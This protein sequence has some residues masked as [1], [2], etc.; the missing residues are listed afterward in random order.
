MPKI[1]HILIV[2]AAGYKNHQQQYLSVL[3]VNQW[4]TSRSLRPHV[5]RATGWGPYSLGLCVLTS[6]GLRVGVWCCVCVEG[7]TNEAGGGRVGLDVLPGVGLDHVPQAPEVGGVEDVEALV[8]PLPPP[9]HVGCEEVKVRV[10]IPLEG[11]GEREG[12]G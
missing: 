7:R 9:P 3:C 10:L 1:K 8:R 4:V 11:E 6:Y 2:F 5:L 12:E